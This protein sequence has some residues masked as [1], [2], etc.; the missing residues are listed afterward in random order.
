MS[1]SLQ[2]YGLQP[3]RLLCPWDSPGK[4]PGVGYHALLQGIFSTQGLNACLFPSPALA[5]GFFTTSTTE[6]AKFIGCTTP[7][8]GPNV[9]YQL[10]VVMIPQCKFNNYIKCCL[11]FL[12]ENVDNGGGYL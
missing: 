4:N 8:V 2:P 11:L 3:P 10:W 9:N 5:G 1:N 12:V 7:R 6:F